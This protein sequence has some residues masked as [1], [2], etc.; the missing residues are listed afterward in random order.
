MFNALKLKVL[1]VEDDLF[2]ADLLEDVLVE[3]GYEV[4]GIARTVDD[5]VQLCEHHK[6]HLAILA[7]RLA[8]GENGGEIVN[9]L[10]TE[11]RPGLLYASGNQAH[12]TAENV[13]GEA[14]LGKPYRSA[15]V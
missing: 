3:G 14:C 1:V 6:P 13:E 10:P 9:R 12:A 8:N 11:A 15:D 4:C 5:A 2:M 7:L